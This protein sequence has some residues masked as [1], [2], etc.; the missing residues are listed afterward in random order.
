MTAVAAPVT[1]ELIR[2][3]AVSIRDALRD[4]VVAR[5]LV[6]PRETVSDE[7][8]TKFISMPAI[9]PDFDLYI[10]KVATIAP[11]SAG[12]STV[13]AVVPMFAASSGRYLGTLDGAEVTNLKCAAVTALVTDVCAAPGSRVLGILGA[14][15]QA[16]QQFLGVSAVRDLAEVR[17]YSR[18]PG[19][20]AMFAA[21]VAAVAA[22][23]VVVCESAEQVSH[24]VDVLSTATTSTVPLPISARLPAH[25]HINC[26]GAHTTES[27]E[28]PAELLSAGVLIVEELRTAVAE[29]GESH[30]GAI[31]LGL[32]V[33]AQAADLWRG[34]TVFASTGCAYLDLI[35]C[36]QLVGRRTGT[37]VSEQEV[38]Q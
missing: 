13:T 30:A 4:G 32:L 3:V 33:T 21:E 29:A 12:G 24:G 14:G 9:S 26:M 31:E 11:G 18:D 38:E 23:E 8:G 25:A 2:T 37:H 1:P 19:R 16:R 5:M 28:V 34:R 36:A 17:I 7:A 27:R 35:T 10:N 20:A 22:V 15:V 6:P